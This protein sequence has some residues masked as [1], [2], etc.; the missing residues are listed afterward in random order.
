[1]GI[2]KYTFIKDTWRVEFPISIENN[3]LTTEGC[4][5]HNCDSMNFIIVIDLERDILYV[6]YKV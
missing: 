6:G 3:I 1:M 5:Q 4:E 2:Q